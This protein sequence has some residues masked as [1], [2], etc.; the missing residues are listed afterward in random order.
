MECWVARS[1]GKEVV[2]E[3]SVIDLGFQGHFS[4]GLGADLSFCLHSIS[5]FPFSC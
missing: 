5:Q 1:G 3:F 2:A 4:T